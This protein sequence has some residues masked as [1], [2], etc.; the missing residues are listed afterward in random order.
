MV[1]IIFGCGLPALRI[2]AGSFDLALRRA[3]YIDP[4][5]CGGYLAEDE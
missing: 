4:G 5:Y 2:S 1:W 3:R